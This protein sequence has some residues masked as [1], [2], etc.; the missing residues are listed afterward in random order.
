MSEKR[1]DAAPSESCSSRV[2]FES[3]YGMCLPLPST[4]ELIT[5][6][7]ADSDRLILVASLRRTPVAWVG[8]DDEDGDS[9]G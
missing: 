1:I 2:S 8:D 7:S 3:R 6:P 5:L 4:S 9:S